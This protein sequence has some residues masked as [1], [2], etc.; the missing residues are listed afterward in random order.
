[1]PMLYNAIKQLIERGRTEGLAEKVD[2]F[3]LVGK[4]TETEYK[5]IT[6]ALEPQGGAEFE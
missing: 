1:M 4:L 3:Y 5:K 6:A 2:V